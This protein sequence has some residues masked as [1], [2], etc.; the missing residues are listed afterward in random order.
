MDGTKQEWDASGRMMEAAGTAF[1]LFTDYDWQIGLQTCP[2]CGEITF[3]LMI[4]EQSPPGSE[5]VARDVVFFE[6]DA[7]PAELVKTAARALGIE[8][9]N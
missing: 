5:A 8:K 4:A 2:C 3:T 7:D 9:V 1:A 6:G